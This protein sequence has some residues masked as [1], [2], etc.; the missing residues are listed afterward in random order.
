M[1]RETTHKIRGAALQALAYPA[2]LELMEALMTNQP[3]TVEELGHA[4]GR[5]PKT[6][7]H[8][9]KPLLAVGLIVEVGERPT[10]KRPAKVYGLPAGHLV[11]DPEDMSPAS[12]EA[13]AKIAKVI[14]RSS[15]NWHTAAMNDPEVV[16]GGKQATLV[17][18]QRIARLR[19]R[20]RKRVVKKLLELYALLGEEHD[21]KGEPFALTVQ[22][23]PIKDGR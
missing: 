3:A 12:V 2:R 13:R 21:P 15:L 4:L 20:G 6:L 22:L 10:S 7:Y 17:L 19:P 8:H 5:A 23:V 9:L 16:I 1:P 18:A 11:V 14:L